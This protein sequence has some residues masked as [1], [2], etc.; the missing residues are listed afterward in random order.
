MSTSTF[1]K[2]TT[3]QTT[4]SIFFKHHSIFAKIVK[5]IWILFVAIL[6]AIPLYVFSVSID[7]FGLFGGMPSLKA[8]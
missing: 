8:G 3:R 2:K 4:S 5:G 6:I 7:L 1:S